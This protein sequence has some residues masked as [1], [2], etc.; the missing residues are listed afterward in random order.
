MAL[1]KTFNLARQN[2][3][4]QQFTS[5]EMTEIKNAISQET[6]NVNVRPYHVYSTDEQEV[7]VTEDGETIYEKVITGLN[8]TL[9]MT[10]DAFH[11]TGIVIQNIKQIRSCVFFRTSD[12]VCVSHPVTR[13]NNNKVQ[14]IT[15]MAASDLNKA[16]VRY[17]KTTDE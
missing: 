12:G 16:V 15:N 3:I 2:E 13:A 7:G 6:A 4:P 1:E 9:L 11:D 14:Y 10:T 5:A 8:L 17:T